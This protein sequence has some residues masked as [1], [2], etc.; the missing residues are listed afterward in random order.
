MSTIGLMIMM[1]Y[2]IGL[3]IMMSY[4][5]LMFM[6]FQQELSLKQ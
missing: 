2:I 4:I 6:M 5:G 1:S 3:M